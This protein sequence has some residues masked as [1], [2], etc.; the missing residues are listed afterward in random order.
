MGLFEELGAL[1]SDVD[2]AG[3]D[4]VHLGDPA[5]RSLSG[6][7]GLL[8]DPAGGLGRLAAALDPRKIIE[9]VTGDPVLVRS[10]AQVWRSGAERTDRVATTLLRGLVP[11]RAGW[12]GAARD[13][14]AAD[15]EALVGGLRS[16]AGTMRAVGHGLDQ[17]ADGLEQAEHLVE[18]LIATLVDFTRAAQAAAAASAELGQPAADAAIAAETV[19]TGEQAVEVVVSLT[20]LVTDVGTVLQASRGLAGLMALAERLPA[21]VEP[22]PPGEQPGA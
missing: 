5:G 14:F 18:Q 11:V 10:A 1:A 21:A 15:L 17:V 9:L 8:V 2:G 22:V 6:G 3:R 12:Q 20:E 16:L 19:Y 13:A 7:E 4:V